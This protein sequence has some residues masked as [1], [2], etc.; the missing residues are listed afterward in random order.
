MFDNSVGLAGNLNVVELGI[1]R[2]P[3]RQIGAE[4]KMCASFRICKECLAETCLWNTECDILL[5]FGSVQLNPARDLCV[6]A[7]SSWTE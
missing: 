3:K 2:R 1:V 6:D 7:F 4:G 5:Q